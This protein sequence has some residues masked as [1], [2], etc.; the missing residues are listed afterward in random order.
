ME[1]KCAAGERATGGGGY[2]GDVY[3]ADA[4]YMNRPMNAQFETTA[5]TAPTSW[6][7][8]VHNGAA[9]ARPLYVAAV[10]VPS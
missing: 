9:V 2:F 1:A 7:L 6:V 4:I 3:P 10:C 5:G 8:Y